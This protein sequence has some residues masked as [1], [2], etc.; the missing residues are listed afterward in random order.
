MRIAFCSDTYLPEINGVTTVVSTMRDGLLARGH[1]VLVLAPRYAAGGGDPDG[2]VRRGAVPCPGYGAVRLSSPFGGD[3]RR[4]LD[5]FAPDLVHLVTEGPIGLIARRWAIRR[6]IALVSSFHTDFPR[7]A[8][9]Y[10][11]AWAVGPTRRYLRWFHRAARITQTPSDT[12]RDELHA[13]GIPGAVSWGRGVD[14]ERFSPRRRDP[15]R[16]AALGADERTPLVL[17]VS[18][19]AVEKDVE[20]LVASFRLAQARL[21]A[22]V[23]FAVAGDG[24]RAAWVRAEL[25]FATHYGFLDRDVL[26]DLYA[27]ADM[28]VFPSPTET[29]GLVVLEAMASGLPVLAANAG[30]VVEHL[31]EGING[32]LLPAGDAAAFAARLEALVEDTPHRI[33][34]SAG[35]LAFASDR[36]WAREMDRLEP[37]YRDAVATTL[38]RPVREEPALA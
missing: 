27:D 8:Q 11:G 26:A 7:Y 3:V 15:A 35:A 4:T 19:L 13:L 30:G 18:R 23:R 34:L 29:C 9:R 16:R 6:Q 24:P 37:M 28:F 21:G 20:T 25:P 5:R 17:H 33:G 36:S 2:V 12:T 31:R 22:R 1:D 32:H 14:T 10:L 38:S